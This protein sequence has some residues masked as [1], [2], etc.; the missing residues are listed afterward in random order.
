MYQMQQTEKENQGIR[1][2]ILRDKIGLNQKDF[3]NEIQVKQPHLSE[4]ERGIKNVSQK[5]LQNIGQRYPNTNISWLLTGEG[6]M[7]LGKN[8]EAAEV[9]MPE[10]VRRIPEIGTGVGTGVLRE[11]EALFEQVLKNQEDFERRLAA[12]EEA[13]KRK[14]G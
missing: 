2:A 3:A 9:E 7:F 14:D 10:S 5:T 8:R 4:M 12:I 6:E 13:R 1:L 11:L